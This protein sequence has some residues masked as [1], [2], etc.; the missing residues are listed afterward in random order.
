MKNYRTPKG[1]GFMEI[2][3]KIYPEVEHGIV[4]R[5][6][7]TQFKYNG[8]PS[9][10]KD[11]RG[12]LFATAS[13]MRMQHVDPSGKNCMWVSFNEGK[14]WTKPIV[15]NDDYLDDRDTGVIAQ[16][17]GYMCIS[18]FTCYD[19]SL[20][21]RF[22]DYEWLN[23][24]DKQLITKWGTVLPLI[25]NVR[26]EEGCFVMVSEDYGVTWSEKIRVP[27]TAPHGPTALKNGDLCYVGRLTEGEYNT[28]IGCYISHDHG[29]TWEFQGL[30]PHPENL[31]ST[32]YLHEPHVIEL[33]N[34]RLLAGIRA[35]C[36]PK[37]Y[38]IEN[39]VL[40]SYSDDGGK[41]WSEMKE[42]GMDGLPPHFM[43][44]S[45]G[46]VLCSYAHRGGQGDSSERVAVSHD[47][48]ETWTE[49]YNIYP[50]AIHHDLGYPATVELSDGS[51]LT[52]YYQF[53]EGDD[54]TSIL[55]TKWK[56]QD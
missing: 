54:N 39:T 13:S 48:G 32:D 35:H 41:T 14:T 25:P 12:V 17:G 15:L 28:R 5:V 42:T 27:L 11:E 31:P 34:G 6:K 50:N 8:W 33:P 16:P 20:Y 37:P 10:C 40:T 47:N 19:E 55:Q 36:L 43:V 30:I 46:A 7:N 24:P 26:D 44:H 4:H 45:S 9:I 3:N 18:F 53:Y 56:L 29:Y 21:A 22:A 51:L 23:E 52:V 2:K 1:Y 49:E 38:S